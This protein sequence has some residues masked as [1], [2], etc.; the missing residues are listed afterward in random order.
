MFVE[1]VREKSKAANSGFKKGDIIIGV[2]QNEIRDLKDLDLA[3]QKNEKKEF[4]KIW[5]YR[6][7]FVTLLVLK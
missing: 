6:N 5:V 3:L 4:I 2:G 1:K 7:G